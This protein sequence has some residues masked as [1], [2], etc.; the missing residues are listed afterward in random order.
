MRKTR[1]L[2][3]VCALAITLAGPSAFAADH[4]DSPNPK[5]D[6]ATDITDVYAWAEG[7]KVLL[8]LNVAPLATAESKFSDA[9]QYALHVESSA[10]FGMAG[11]SKDV[12]CTFDAA[13]KV[14]CW[15]GDPGGKAD[16]YVTG[17]ASDTNGLASDSG[18]M[19]VYAGLRADPFYFNLEGFKDAVQTVKDSAAA[20]MFD[21]DGCPQLDP[22]TATTLQGML[23]GTM[24]GTGNAENFFEM[25][26]VLSIVLEVD[27]ALL[28]GGGSTLAVW[29]ST[30]KGG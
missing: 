25:V 9:V 17:D 14:Q 19:K 7:G 22:I 6:P 26:N 13:Q 24:K 2:Q 16:D 28:T 8:V 18:K 4:L 20:L 27:K 30:H 12:V 1:W 10:G 3:G 29:G 23:Q 11:T 21:A 5:K 15:I